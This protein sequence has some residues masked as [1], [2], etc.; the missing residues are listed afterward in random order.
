MDLAKLNEAIRRMNNQGRLGL[1]IYVIP[2][3]PNPELFDQTKTLLEA[4]P[5]VTLIETTFPVSD[6]YSIY[7][8]Q[9]IIKA[10]RQAL[11]YEDGLTT[12]DCLKGFSKPSIAVLYQETFDRL[13][14]EAILGKIKGKIDALLFEWEIPEV[15]KYIYSYEEYNLEL[16]QCIVPG[17]NQKEIEYYLSLAI[18]QPLIYLVS[19]S[20][21]GG[22][23]FDEKSISDCIESIM[24]YKPGA[25]ICA[26][27]G[28]K[29]AG[30]IKKLSGLNNLHGV[31]IGT[32]FLEIMKDGMKAVEDYLS[33]I[34]ESLNLR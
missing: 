33:G 34:S 19:A 21:T 24:K 6:H 4:H 23:L 11:K 2:N 30:D 3:Y 14:Y 17:M 26:G 18:D 1:I 5:D 13:G 10:H 22:E 32:V 8:N 27:F 15:Q 29:N 16:I 7:A 20:M 9:T 31:I 25:R 28:I 12:L